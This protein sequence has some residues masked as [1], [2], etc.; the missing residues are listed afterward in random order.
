M[1]TLAHEA[2]VDEY[3]DDLGRAAERVRKLSLGARDE[4][5]VTY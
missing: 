1:V 4:R 5:V 3:L 2:A